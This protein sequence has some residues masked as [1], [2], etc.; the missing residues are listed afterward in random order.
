M[1]AITVPQD[2]KTL[3]ASTHEVAAAIIAALPT[4]AVYVINQSSVREHA[5]LAWILN[6]VCRMGWLE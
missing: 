1:H 5:E 2:P 6:C 3:R 4:L